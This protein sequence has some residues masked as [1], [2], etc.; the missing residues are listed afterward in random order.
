MNQVAISYEKTKRLEQ[1]SERTLGLVH[2]LISLIEENTLGRGTTDLVA[3]Y[4]YALASRLQYPKEYLKDLMFGTVLRDI[5]MI[6]VSDLIVRSP[7]ELVKEEWEIIKRHPSE[8]AEMLKKMR[9][10]KHTT[11]IVLYHHERF[12]GEGYP[13][14]LEGTNIPLGAR[15]VSL[16]ESYAAM[17]RDRPNRP[18]LKEEEALNTLRENWGLR[19]DPEVVKHFVALVEE[20]RRSKEKIKYN[21]SELFRIQGDTE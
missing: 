2:T 18:A 19:Y 3:N 1:E 12:N 16:T 11:D 9:F 4:T 15:I 5:G 7:R 8:G 6:K 13:A 17:L 21:H 10:S 14:G 20:E